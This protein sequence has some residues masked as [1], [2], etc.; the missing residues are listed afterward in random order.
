MGREISGVNCEVGDAA[1]L[2]AN[3]VSD[4]QCGESDGI[5]TGQ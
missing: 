4:L 3:A 2:R 5:V 1:P